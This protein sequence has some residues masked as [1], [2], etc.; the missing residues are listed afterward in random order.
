MAQPAAASSLASTLASLERILSRSE[1]PVAD[2]GALADPATLALLFGVQLGTMVK[3][4]PAVCQQEGMTPARLLA[5]A[6]KASLAGI[7][8]LS[9]PPALRQRLHDLE[10]EVKAA[11]AWHPDEPLWWHPLPGPLSSE[12]LWSR[13]ERDPHTPLAGPPLESL[14]QVFA[15]QP[16]AALWLPLPN[17]LP[18]PTVRELFDEVEK[19]FR[20]GGLVLER[21]GVGATGATSVHRW[22]EITFLS[23]TETEL[24]EEA[25]TL[26][27]FVQWCL[28]PWSDEL[29]EAMPHT[30]IFPPQRAMLARYPAPCGGYA[31]HVDNPGGARDNG[32]ALTL[33]LYLNPADHACQGGELLV[34]Q[35]GA[36]AGDPVAHFV[37]AEG[38]TAI[39]FDARAIP[40]QVNPVREGPDRWALTLWFNDS[41]TQPLAV[42]S[43]PR[44]TRD[45]VLLP[46]DDPPLDQ[47]VV[48]FHEL[49]DGT[50]G[51]R[52]SVHQAV[53][54]W[55]RVGLVSTVARGGSSL[56][57]W[58]A[59]HAS[60]G[61]EHIVLI[62]D[63]LDDPQ[64]AADAAR[65]AVSHL[66][67]RL[68]VWSGEQLQKEGWPALPRGRELDDLRRL[69]GYGG[70]SFAV[71]ARQ[72][73]N[74][75]TALAAAREGLLGGE[76]L[77]WL[78][79]LDLDEWFWLQGP[80]RGGAKLGEHFATATAAGLQQVRYVNHELLLPGRPD[81]LLR[82]KV[83]PRL[84]IARLGPRGWAR[85]VEHLSMAQTD[86]RPYFRGYTNGKSAVRVQSGAL[87]AGV[88]G[89]T[90]ADLVDAAHQT[91]V[92][93][94][95]VLHFHFGSMEGFRRK[96]LAMA[97]VVIPEGLRQFDPSPVEVE[98]V[99]VVR[100]L[101]EAG[102]G[103][104]VVAEHLDRL[105][106]RVTSFA[107]SEIEILEAAGVILTPDL[108]HRPLLG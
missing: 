74:A 82:F 75:S 92:A 36:E 8:P 80:G 94:P 90:L 78:L 102:V 54:P 27:A 76:P 83:N 1:Q 40:H 95:S 63:H 69:A 5:I 66:P 71:A 96:Y 10:T 51:G 47:G 45:D 13:W 100:S 68:T 57:A 37:R 108:K 25:P 61:F 9:L 55:P 101:R 70:A 93:G 4:G 12:E 81:A 29:A 53:P 39:L 103:P 17:H 33:V 91:I 85:L 107:E 28:G 22:D 20:A 44:L 106:R 58:C 43:P 2:L 52:I 72:S 88:H 35:P 46:V 24:L 48:L 77:D 7:L 59:H 60:R 65:M 19:A 104:D 50:A 26:A 67:S 105:Y 30:L 15:G 98:A 14:A 89:W 56:D 99:R 34:W 42:L 87:A 31:A 97:D 86:P 11:G 16:G 3:S 41:P 38:G 84:A 73:L 32:R 18:A 49:D 64:D 79:H 21:G 6:G 62:F 23:G